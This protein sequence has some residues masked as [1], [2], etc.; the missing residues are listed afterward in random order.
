[1]ENLA[2]EQYTTQD[3]LKV[4]ATFTY[5][6]TLAQSQPVL[7]DWGWC[8]KDQATLTDNLNKIQL[9][10]TLN[11]QAVELSKFVKL[12]GPLNGQQCETYVLGLTDWSGGQN[13]A[14]TTATFTAPVNDGTYDYPAGKQ[15]SDYTIYVNP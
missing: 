15:V 2:R 11:G 12:V 7:W 10:F 14:I 3:T 9:A 4:P 8:A 5:T 1:L 6:I 13:E